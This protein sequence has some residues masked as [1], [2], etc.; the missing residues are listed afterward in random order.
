MSNR[1]F[2]SDKNSESGDNDFE[3]DQMGRTREELAM[4]RDVERMQR[5]QDD[6]QRRIDAI[7]RERMQNESAVEEA[8]LA[9][10]PREEFSREPERVVPAETQMSLGELQ[11]Q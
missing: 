2:G 11:T 1:D 7:R 10:R 9:D 6:S 4:E 8:V 5:R 3:V